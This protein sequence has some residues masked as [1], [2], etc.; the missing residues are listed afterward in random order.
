MRMKVWPEPLMVKNVDNYIDYDV[1]KTPIVSSIAPSST[2]PCGRKGHC[3]TALDDSAPVLANTS[4]ENV[5]IFAV[6]IWST[7]AD[8]DQCY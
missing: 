3:A 5:Y 1:C 4:G 6:D 7:I 2:S 8:V